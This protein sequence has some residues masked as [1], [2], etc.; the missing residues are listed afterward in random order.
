LKF[1][2]EPAEEVRQG[3]CEDYHERSRQ[4]ILAGHYRTHEWGIVGQWQRD[5]IKRL[6]FVK[7]LKNTGDLLEIHVKQPT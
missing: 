3:I 2:R 1:R 6:A 4:S 7:K 5:L